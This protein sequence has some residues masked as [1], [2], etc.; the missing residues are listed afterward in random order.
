[1]KLSR[2]TTAVIFSFVFIFSAV[3]SLKAQIVY[4]DLSPDKK[5]EGWDVY[6]LEIDQNTALDIWYHPGEVVIRSVT[7]NFEVSVDN[8]NLPVA[9][10]KEV[11]IDANSTWLALGTSYVMLW[12]GTTGNW[13]SKTD[14]Y[15]PLR[16]KKDG[17]W[18][19]MWVKMDVDAQ[20]TYFIVQEYAY[21]SVAGASIKAGEG[22]GTAGIKRNEFQSSDVAVY[23]NPCHGNFTV[24]LKKE[25]R[26]AELSIV[27]AQGQ[28]VSKKK[29]DGLSTVESLP[30]GI[31]FLHIKQGN[32]VQTKQVIVY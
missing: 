2:H 3:F 22:E 11:V 9:L 7:N 16:F 31:Y 14:K 20:P 19:Y 8:Q 6:V 4:T 32:A 12:N 15:L 17:T 13:G 28:M 18:R 23:P 25:S 27:N 1:M 26:G 24:E 21:N 5:V 10:E 30:L 29:M